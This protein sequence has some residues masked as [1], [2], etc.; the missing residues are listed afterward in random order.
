M[1][2]PKQDTTDAMTTTELVRGYRTLNITRQSELL[3]GLDD[4]CDGW[5][6]E[7]RKAGRGFARATA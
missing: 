7:R 4:L 1:D 3:A 6:T 5:R 2:N